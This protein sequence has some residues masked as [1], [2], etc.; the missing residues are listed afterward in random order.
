MSIIFL[1]ALPVLMYFLLIRPQQKRAKEQKE[2]LSAVEEGDEVMTTGGLYGYVNAVEGETIWLEIAENVEIR[3][4]KAAVLEADPPGHRRQRR[5][6]PTP[7]RRPG[8]RARTA[9]RPSSPTTRPP[10]SRRRAPR[11][12]SA[13]PMNTRSLWASLIGIV[14][15][16]ILGLVL[17]FAVGNTPALGLDLQG[18][19]SVVLQP[20]EGSDSTAIDTAIDIIRNRVDGLGVAEPEITRQGDAV[21]VN[22]PGVKDQDRALEVVGQTAELRFRPVL[23]A[24][25]PDEAD[26]EPVTSTTVPGRDD[27]RCR[28]HDDRR[29]CHDHCRRRHHRAGCDDR[30]G[31]TT[32]P[33]ATTTVPST[34]VPTTPAEQDDPTKE[35]VLRGARRRRE[36]GR[37]AT[38][39]ARPS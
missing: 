11:P 37:C 2:L 12:S 1:L 24:L 36:R 35:V 31:A 38:A 15:V 30:A 32:V 25:P 14:A 34:I 13:E 6:A 22:L 20:K 33:G 7:R 26:A 19:A 23:E 8:R 10:R 29:R 27:H 16:A 21:V 28:C 4:A 9:R 18:G 3:I 17:T 39:W 5:D